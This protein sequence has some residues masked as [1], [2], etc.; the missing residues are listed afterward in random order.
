MRTHAT[1]FEPT[2]D[3][4]LSDPIVRVLM[5]RDGVR[6]EDVRLLV[7]DVAGRLQRTGFRQR[8]AAATPFSDD[9]PFGHHEKKSDPPDEPQPDAWTLLRCG[10]AVRRRADA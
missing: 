2:L 3:E 5:Q 9:V 7:R 10:A 1:R 8:R 6:D 4:M